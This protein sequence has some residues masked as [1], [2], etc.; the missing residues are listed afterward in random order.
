MADFE[1]TL[2][3]GK[4]DHFHLILIAYMNWCRHIAIL[5]ILVIYLL[6]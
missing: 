4:M 5:Y 2:R 1:M 3:P 6:N